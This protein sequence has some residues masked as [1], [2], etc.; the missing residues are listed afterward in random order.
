MF[1]LVRKGR[2]VMNADGS[3]RIFRNAAAMGRLQRGDQPL[4]WR[5]ADRLV[6]QGAGSS[7]APGRSAGP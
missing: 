7:D 4:I 1:Y 2:P 6:D 5:G 3:V